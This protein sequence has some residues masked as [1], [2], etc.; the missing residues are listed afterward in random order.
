MTDPIFSILVAEDEESQRN[1]LVRFLQKRGYTVFSAPDVRQALDLVKSEV[2]DLILT[3]FKMPGGTGL[4]LIREAKQIS[5]ETDV[6]V[7]TAYGN[8]ADAVEMMKL[9]A[10]DFLTKP[11]DLDVLENLILRIREKHSLKAENKNLKETLERKYQLSGII[12][13]S[14]EME[15]VLNLAARVAPS[16]ATVLIR[17]ESGTGKELV[18]RAIHYGSPRKAKPL[19]TM[20]VAA[21]NEGTLESELFGHEKGS[22]TGASQQRTGRFEQADGGTLF[23]DEVG[24]IPLSVQVK[25]LRAIQFGS[26]ERIGGNQQRHADVR[27]VAATH[28]NL[29]EMIRTG[30]FREDLFY[31]L[32]VVSVDIPPLRKRRTDIQALSD[33][34]IRKFAEENGKPVTGISREAFDK[35]MKYEFPG[36]VR[37]LQ[38]LLER[39]VIL[40]R[41]DLITTHD[42][43]ALSPADPA[44][45]F[46][47]ASLSEGYEK[48]LKEFETAMIREALRQSSG[49]QTAAARIL[50]ISE[51]HLRSRLERLDLK[52]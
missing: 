26:F 37:E 48:K 49:N 42:L 15:E 45:V 11:I 34:F 52:K 21:F 29:E 50:G 22:F 38:N 51:R 17:G 2:T 32:N 27:I 28:R 30:A 9:G 20:N 24:D 8:V 3:D 31:R 46:D 12:S 18:A 14:P 16:K 43:P 19:V 1:A 36:N 40:C 35:L 6:V 25:L 7:M 5:P 13:K 44:G 39:A 10:Y 23:I 41:G 47:P 33:H 4:D